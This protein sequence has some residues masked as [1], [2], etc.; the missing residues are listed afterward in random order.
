MA[1]EA[2]ETQ[3]HR[4]CPGCEGSGTHKKMAVKGET[5]VL[6][7]VETQGTKTVKVG[8]QGEGSVLAVERARQRR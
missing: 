5:P 1:A 4:E 7:R 8:T 6:F 3:V 2:A